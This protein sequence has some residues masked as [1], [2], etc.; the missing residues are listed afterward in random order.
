MKFLFSLFALVI[1][2]TLYAI[3]PQEGNG[4]RFCKAFDGT[5]R[6]IDELEFQRL[7]EGNLKY[8]ASPITNRFTS[9]LDSSISVANL[10]TS[11]AG[12]NVENKFK[13]ILV[14]DPALGRELL[15][16]FK[17]LDY[18]FITNKRF[19]VSQ[20]NLSSN[21]CHPGTEEVAIQSNNVGFV[22]I[23]EMAWN[24]LPLST[25]ELLL[26]HQTLKFAQLH[27]DWFNK[28]SEGN[29][30]RFSVLINLNR[31]FG[32]KNE[33]FYHHLMKQNDKYFSLPVVQLEAITREI[34][35]KIE[36]A[37]HKNNFS[38]AFKL[39]SYAAYVDSFI[40]LNLNRENFGSLSKRNFELR[41]HR[42][43][44]EEL[45]YDY[46]EIVAKND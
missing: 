2:S 3:D 6:T 15:Q 18:V 31:T 32:V 40:D 36:A 12:R 41:Q 46:E 21:K 1:S 8:G 10:T 39:N 25:Q 27:S 45:I 19:P 16:Y 35:S 29:I 24:L 38:L 34:N 13:Q 30:Q 14:H 4:A 26:I 42:P 28:T 11:A 22:L 44:Y 23:S 7:P 33:E 20:K 9:Y 17:M 5:F 37:L 43:Y